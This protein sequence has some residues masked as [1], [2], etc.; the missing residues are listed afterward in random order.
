[1]E[2]VLAVARASLVADGG[3]VG[4]GG[5]SIRR[6]L[7]VNARQREGEGGEFRVGRSHGYGA[8]TLSFAH[9]SSMGTRLSRSKGGAAHGYGGRKI[10]TSGLGY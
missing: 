3:S 8:V 7:D 10:R 1:M 2:V 4:R 5:I 6:R 9:L